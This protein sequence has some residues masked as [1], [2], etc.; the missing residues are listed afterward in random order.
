M[1]KKKKIYAEVNFKVHKW[2]AI[3][4]ILMSEVESSAD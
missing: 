3:I 2:G 4:N 1:N